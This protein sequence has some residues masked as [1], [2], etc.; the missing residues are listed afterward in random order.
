MP[1]GGPDVLRRRLKRLGWGVFKGKRKRFVVDN[2]LLDSS[3]L[4]PLNISIER[5]DGCA[6]EGFGFLQPVLPL[7]QFQKYATA[8]EKRIGE[9]LL[10]RPEAVS[11]ILG[12][13]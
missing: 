8:G 6:H 12:F 5:F 13:S 10:E 1:Q 4:F 2:R 7:S 11:A 9:P 3:G